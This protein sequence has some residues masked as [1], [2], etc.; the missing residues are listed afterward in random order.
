MDVMRDI[1]VI[2]S[3]G[4]PGR[5]RDMHVIGWDSSPPSPWAQ[6]VQIS[7]ITAKSVLGPQRA[8]LIV[9]LSGTH[10]NEGHSDLA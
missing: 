10:P 1:D 3:A 9:R 6:K 7:G 5:K 8:S 4:L 2:G